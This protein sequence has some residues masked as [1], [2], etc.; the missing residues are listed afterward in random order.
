[1]ESDKYSSVLSAL[2]SLLEIAVDDNDIWKFHR[3]NEIIYVSF[4]NKDR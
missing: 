4:I 1:M 2:T 3:K